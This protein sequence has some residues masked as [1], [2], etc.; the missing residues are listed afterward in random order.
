[1]SKDAKRAALWPMLLLFVIY[2][3]FR[4]ASPEGEPREELRAIYLARAISEHWSVRIND[5]VKEHGDLEGK[6]H[7][8]ND[9]YAGG[10]PGLA[11]ISVP[12][13]LLAKGASWLFG[14]ELNNARALRYLR[15]V[16][17]IIP[18]CIL[19]L[20]LYVFLVRR[21][22]H[23]HA[24]RFALLAC[25]LS[26][27]LWVYATGLKGAHLA[28]LC[29]LA[30]LVL[31]GDEEEWPSRASFVVAGLL[32]A[33]SV[34]LCYAALP[35]AVLV[36]LYAFTRARSPQWAL[37][38]LAP[39]LLGIAAMCAFHYMTTQLIFR[40]VEGTAADGSMS[41]TFWGLHA[42]RLAGL[43]WLF[44]SNLGLLRWAPVL[45]LPALGLIFMFGRG[46]AAEALVLG[47]GI[48]FSVLL[49]SG[50]PPP[51]EPLFGSP[52]MALAILLA[53]WPTARAAEAL[54]GVAG[55]SLLA[56]V[57]ACWSLTQSALLVSTHAHVP[58]S[59]LNPLRDLSVAMLRDGVYAQ[60]IGHGIG[61]RGDFAVAPL[62]IMVFAVGCAQSLG[63]SPLAEGSGTRRVLSA[64]IFGGALLYWQLSWAPEPAR[65]ERYLDT[66]AIENATEHLRGPDARLSR[67]AAR[68]WESHPGSQEARLARGRAAT[69]FGDNATALE[70]YRNL[71]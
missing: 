48:I 22:V 32:G 9:M 36:G 68:V 3:Y 52:T 21:S 42:P 31:L 70:Q 54:G 57:L 56:G 49:A 12:P 1:M 6:L 63:G 29:L 23:A 24:A 55:G 25:A 27:P 51:S 59:Y 62:F 71:P 34:M 20:L 50:E 7:I 15:V 26:A 37:G 10:A 39:L 17:S 40:V 47:L 33:C 61:L 45:A 30:C 64:I 60:S 69:A 19:L 28:G 53:V 4:H 35:A 44:F 5:V 16:V 13:L 41:T 2:P 8:E 43:D 66:L 38:Y 18:T 14:F 67:A 58:S 46:D 11:F 65:R